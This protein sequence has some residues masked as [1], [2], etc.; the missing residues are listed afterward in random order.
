VIINLNNHFDACFVITDKTMFIFHL[1]F[2]LMFFAH[3]TLLIVATVCM[4]AKLRGTHDSLEHD[5]V[6]V[7]Q[8]T[9]SNG[10]T[11]LGCTNDLPVCVSP[12]G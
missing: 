9:V 12:R 2:D 4:A 5:F 8:N 3:A 1:F 11:N 6:A 7:Y 10:V